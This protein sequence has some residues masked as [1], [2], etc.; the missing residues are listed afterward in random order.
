MRNQRRTPNSGNVSGSGGGGGPVNSN[1]GSSTPGLGNTGPTDSLL[2]SS[3]IQI[4]SLSPPRLNL[5]AGFG[6]TMGSMYSSIHPAM[7]M[8]ESYR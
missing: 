8:S 6:S 4:P 3:H 2:G 7:P 1:L 5:N